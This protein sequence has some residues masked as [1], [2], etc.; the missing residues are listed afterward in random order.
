MATRIKLLYAASTASHLRRFHMPY[1]N[2]LR[3]EHDV[4]L[5]GTAG[6][7]IDF[8]IDFAKSIFSFSNLRAIFKIRKILKRERFDRVIVHT[9][10]AAFLVRMAMLG[11]RR[12]PRVLNVVHGYLFSEPAQGLKAKLMRFC[13]KLLRGKT[14][15]L[16]VMNREDLEIAEK[17]RL[18][19]G[20][21]PSFLYGM[22]IPD[23]AEPPA[24]DDALRASFAA[25]NEI[26]LTFVGEL[27]HRKNQIFLIRAAEELKRRGIPVKLLLAG[28]GSERE[29]LESEIESRALTDTVYLPGNLEPIRP[30]LGIT[31]IY[32]SASTSEG[33]PF[34]VMEAMAAGLPVVMSDTKGQNDLHENNA[35][36]LYPLDDTE[37]F[38]KAVTAV[39]ES[40]NYGVGSRHYPH[41]EKYRLSAVFAD[42]LAVL[43][44]ECSK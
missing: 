30:Y 22:G 43:K 38:C 10:L 23:P 3:A 12:R 9:T 18:C 28:E 36:Q 14:D 1:I 7:G 11:M 42:D 31:D 21:K 4:F 33:L 16:A 27:S 37:A 39:Y 17:Y 8:P 25:E 44:G 35:S 41:L 29:T 6:D 20:G 15:E 40:G 32:A 13:E 34:N 24:R 19:A 26:L 2:A 5:M